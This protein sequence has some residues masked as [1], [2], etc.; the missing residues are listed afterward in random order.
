MRTGQYDGV[1]TIVGR[2]GTTYDRPRAITECGAKANGADFVPT[3]AKSALINGDAGEMCPTCK[4]KLEANGV[5]NLSQLSERSRSST[6][7]QRGFIRR[8][9]D[10]GARNGRPYLID[11]RDID[12]MSSRS[13]S[14][15]I[16]ALQSL[17]A[18]NWKGDL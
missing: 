8:L 12:Q 16:D 2:L 10:D 14:A 17:K 13:A 6:P 7:K 1:E 11:A 18:S 15:A 4:A 3:A 5:R 9:L